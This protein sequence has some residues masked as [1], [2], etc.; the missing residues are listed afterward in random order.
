MNWVRV[1]SLSIKSIGSTQRED[2][3]RKPVQKESN[4]CKRA[5]RIWLKVESLWYYVLTLLSILPSEENKDRCSCG[6][7]RFYCWYRRTVPGQRENKAGEY[8]PLTL[9]VR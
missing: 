2:C 9:V 6:Q 5:M 8:A 1:V 3:V 7:L 4:E